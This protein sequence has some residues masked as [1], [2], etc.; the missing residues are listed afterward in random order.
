MNKLVF[1]LIASIA[2]QAIVSES[3]C[4]L[5][6]CLTDGSETCHTYNKTEDGPETIQVQKCKDSTKK[7]PEDF[8]STKNATCTAKPE[9]TGL[10]AGEACT[11]ESNCQEGLKCENN[12]CTGKDKEAACLNDYEC[13]PG[14]YCDG[15]NCKELNKVGSTC[16]KDTHCVNNALCMGDKCVEIFSLDDGQETNN[17]L[18]CKSMHLYL[19]TT[20]M[21]SYC[22]SSELLTSKE[23]PEEKKCIY[24]ITLGEGKEFNTTKEC[25]CKA[26]DNTKLYC[27]IGSTSDL[28]KDAIQ[29]KK[30]AFEDTKNKHV[31]LK[32]A[33][34][35]FD[36]NKK[37]QKATLSPFLDD[38]E[39]CMLDAY[40]ST[41]YLKISFLGLLIFGLLF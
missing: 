31:T 40:L 3:V 34:N 21:K 16:K 39:D 11:K 18:L 10:P 17:E 2:I 13:K 7:C 6:K 9:V 24:K 15:S 33:T 41:S 28:H 5:Y 23:C 4:P 12:V 30:D 19:N 8:R 14:L 1:A 29:A 36:L 20:E 27:Q 26:T 25:A 37:I 38:A 32:G 35:K 22:A